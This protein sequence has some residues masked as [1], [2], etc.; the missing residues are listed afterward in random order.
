[1]THFTYVTTAQRVR[2]LMCILGLALLGSPLISAGAPAQP[3]R[4]ATSI[5]PTYTW[6][7]AL[8]RE[9]PDATVE[10]LTPPEEDPALWTP[11][12]SVLSQYQRAS[13]IA[14]NGARFEKWLDQVSLPP[15]R[16]FET[17]E[18]IKGEWLNYPNAVTHQHGPEGA[19]SHEG[20][21]GH[22]WL[23]PISALKQAT[24]LAERFKA[25]LPQHTQLITANLSTL[26][27]RLETLDQRWL[28]F[29]SALK[30]S[31]QPVIIWASHPAYQYLA[32]RYQLPI[33]SLDLDPERPVSV[34]SLTALKAMREALPTGSHLVLW[35]EAEPSEEAQQSLAPL[36][37][38][39]SVT[40]SPLET[41]TLS[42]AVRS[43]REAPD[44]FQRAVPLFKALKATLPAPR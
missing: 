22:T 8:L 32:R 9:I 18:V 7:R 24:S 14:L 42:E 10:L 6:A 40:V 31:P 5:Y 16:T 29:A 13:L 39:A 4:V 27:E 34:E 30:A 12:P 1:M 38:S 11:S 20:V 15:S 44:Y 23:D 36:K 26:K 25:D 35:W 3:Y 21:D 43:G 28:S 37:L 17:A 33:T 41:A 2:R 19:H